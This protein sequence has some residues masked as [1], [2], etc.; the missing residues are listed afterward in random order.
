LSNERRIVVDANILIS[1]VLGRRV[2]QLLEDYGDDV[3]F[4]APQ[5]AFDDAARHLPKLYAYNH[6][7]PDAVAACR[8][9]FA[10][11]PSAVHPIPAEFYGHLHG[12]AMARIGHRDPDDWP[13]IATAIALDAPIWTDDQDF[14]G[15][16]IATWSTT[17]VEIYLREL[18][19]DHIG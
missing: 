16:G 19:G 18:S 13:F 10:A 12:K 14:F 1:A 4:A 11:L 5:V 6:L 8:D 17:I 9:Y 3:L 15:T 7:G 2:R